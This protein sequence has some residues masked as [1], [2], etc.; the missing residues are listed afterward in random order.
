MRSDSCPLAAWLRLLT[1]K[2]YL[3]SC[4]TFLA[5]LEVASWKQK[6]CFV[7]FALWVNERRVQTVCLR[8]KICMK[9]LHFFFSWYVVYLQSPF[10][11]FS[12][13]KHS[14]AIYFPLL[15]Q[16]KTNTSALEFLTEMIALGIFFSPFAVFNVHTCMEKV[17]G[18]I[19]IFP[20]F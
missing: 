17:N 18:N 1:K 6:S 16:C 3:G 10:S 7:M 5:E 14:A 8:G 11:N 19:S 4:L 15:L 13:K 12:E 20:C 2:S 9:F